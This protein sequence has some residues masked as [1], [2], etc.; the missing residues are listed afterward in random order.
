VSGAADETSAELA[1]PRPG[2]YVPGVVQVR[3]Q[4]PPAVIAAAAEHLAELHGNAW[5]PGTR[6]P[7]RHEGGDQ[8]LY[9]TL[10]VPVPRN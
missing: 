6:K 3:L 5:Q 9:G 2:S 10:I 7:S 4:G 8:M 1:L